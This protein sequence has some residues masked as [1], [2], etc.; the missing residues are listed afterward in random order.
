MSPALERARLLL[1]QSRFELAEK[2]L[3]EALAEEPDNFLAHAWLA[4]CFLNTDRDAEAEAEAREAVHLGPD[5][6][7]AHYVH[8]LALLA[9]RRFPEAREA[10]E[11]AMRLDPEDPD[12]HWLQGIVFHAAGRPSEALAAADRGLALDPASEKCLNLRAMALTLLGRKDEADEAAAQALQEAPESADAHANRGWAFLHANDPKAA[13]E[14]FREAMR[15]DPGNDWARAGL[16]EALK[17]R[18]FLYRTLLGYF[19]WMA[20]LDPRVGMGLIFGGYVLFRILRVYMKEHPETAPWLL[21]LAGLY[22]G[23]WLLTWIGDPLSNLLLRL[24]RYGRHAL[25]RTERMG[26][27]AFGLLLLAGL[28]SVVAG[29]LANSPLLLA[30]AAYFVL[31]TI[32]VSAAF[33][34]AGR[35]RARLVAGSCLLVAALGAAA[36]AGL[37][38]DAEWTLNAA[39]AFSVAF[40]AFQWVAVAAGSARPKV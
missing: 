13:L 14:A 24:N 31:M 20:R 12:T 21:P 32:P 9:R 27:N 37:A 33:G 15:L 5:Q 10:A 19:L 40:V 8:G 1:A 3:R 2:F 25:G 39:M 17:A 6:S 18:N 22:I 26:S 29:L 28:L 38:A 30:A 16:V 11:E 4:I 34:F 7:Y 36:L 35:P 23:F